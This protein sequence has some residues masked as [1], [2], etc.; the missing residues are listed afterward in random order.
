MRVFLASI[1]L[2]GRTVRVIGEGHFAE[3]KLRLFLT[4]PAKIVWH[5]T[6]DGPVA[7]DIAARVTIS[8]RPEPKKKALRETALLFVAGEPSERIK[9]LAKRYNVMLNVV[10]SPAQ[11]SFQTP[12]LIDRGGVVAAVATGGAAPLL[13]RDLRSVV[14]SALPN[15]IGLLADLAQ[16]V[17]ATVKSV[18]PKFDDRRH[19]WARALRGPARDRALAGDEAGAR[20]AL[21][22][23]LNGPQEAPQGVVH[24]VGAGPGD[25][26]LL[27]LKALRL[28]RDADVVVHD[29]LV[30]AAILDRVRRDARRIDVG[31]T[32]G[33]HPVPQDAIADI[34][35]DEAKAGNRVVRLKGGD[36]FVFGRGGEELE[37]LQDAGIE[38]YVVPGVSAAMACAAAAGVPLTHRDHAQ[39]ASFVSAV[40]KTGGAQPDWAALATANHTVAVYMG[41]GAAASVREGLTAAGRDPA[42][43]VA[44]VE[45][46]SLPDERIVAGRLWDLDDL[47]AREGVSGP[48]IILIGEAAGRALAR[49]N[50]EQGESARESVA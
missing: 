19:Y 8:D 14:E 44:V 42:T 50:Q 21:L 48:A 33:S 11:S 49:F 37:R 22:S 16:D 34:L 10:D 35:I 6:G 47:I 28:L 5:K 27:T 3:A 7:A 4:S 40:V 38:A 43:P 30:P 15:G 23:E 45:N 46:G 41:V 2:E 13:A 12:A 29:R 18:L 36:P 26:D 9:R 25:P 1:P 39:A 31:K 32:K 17:R 24:L 20:R